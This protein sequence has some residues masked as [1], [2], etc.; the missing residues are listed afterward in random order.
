MTIEITSPDVE[1][2]IRERMEAGSF[3][4]PEDLIREVLKSS[5][6][7]KTLASVSATEDRR[8]A[9]RK[10]LVEVFAPVRG[11]NLEFSRDQS[12]SRR[13]DLGCVEASSS[14]QMFLRN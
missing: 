12:A 10:S 7:E 2:L 5:S 14:I 13:V 11:M 9:G 6:D 1:A 3:K 8:A 4:N